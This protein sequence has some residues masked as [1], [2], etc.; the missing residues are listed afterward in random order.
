MFD[1]DGTL[2][3]TRQG[4]VNCMYYAL[5][6]LGV[7][8]TQEPEIIELIGIPLE[9][10]FIRLLNND[11][12][13][14]IERG[15]RYFRERYSMQ[16]LQELRLYQ[17]VEETLQYLVTCNISLYI[18]TSKPHV[19]VDTICRNLHIEKYFSYVSGVELTGRSLSKTKRINGILSK[20]ALQASQTIMVG[21]R[22]E[23]IIAAKDN[24]LLSIGV[25]IGFGSKDELIRAGCDYLVEDFH[26]IKMIIDSKLF[27]V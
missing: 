11:R 9:D 7:D 3:D 27:Q 22:A 15:V 24:S 16:G 18:V 20:F 25:L 13:D 21:D 14:L 10:M 26:D 17:R 2:V 12:P 5:A 23:D 1:F 8:G 4:I 6:K 19:F